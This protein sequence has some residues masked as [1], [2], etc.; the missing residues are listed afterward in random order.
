MVDK[1]T[2]KE[3]AEEELKVRI[4]LWPRRPIQRVQ[5]PENSLFS[6]LKKYLLSLKQMYEYIN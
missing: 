4:L 2:A 5:E 1:Y 3:D 6:W